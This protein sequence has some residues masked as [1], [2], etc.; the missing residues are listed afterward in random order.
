VDVTLQTDVEFLAKRTARPVYFASSAGRD[1]RYTVDQEM[2]TVTVDVEDARGRTEGD[3]EREYGQHPSGFDLL[4]LPTRVDDFLDRRQIETLYEPEVTAFLREVTG[5]RRVHLFDHTL[6]ASDPELRERKQVREPATLVHNDY[7]SNSGFVCL[8]E[9]LGD[10]AEVMVQ[11][12]FQILNVWRP[13]S[14]PV[15]DYPLALVDSR[16]LAREQLVD[17]E[18]RS[19]T[20]VGEIQLALHDPAQRW[21][22]FSAM[23]PPEV[24]L[25]RTFDSID[26]GTRPCSI[27]TAIHLP[28]AP[29][30][31]KPRESIET[32]ALVFYD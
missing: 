2:V 10:E 25:F 8:R 28:D 21:C 14:D 11:R 29:D 12:R 7:T 32:R 26:D 30:D 17:T 24:L 16:T 20:H 18:R 1:A 15:E 3:A 13:L 4:E 19:P 23:R 6:R 31:A 5:A 27:H 9:S 22:Y